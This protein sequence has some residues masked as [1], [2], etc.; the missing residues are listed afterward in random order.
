MAR[1]VYYKF[2]SSR[3]Y[4]SIPIDAPFISVSACKA[5]IFASKRY[6]IGK[7]FDLLISHAQTDEQYADGS[8]LIPA[9][10]S[11]L[12]RRVPGNPQLPIVIGEEKEK[13]NIK[14]NPSS[15]VND[16]QEEEEEKG[17]DF[18][19]FGLDFNS[20]PKNSTANPSNAHC[21]E[22]KTDDGFKFLAVKRV[23]KDPNPTTRLCLP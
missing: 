14:N 1:V 7:D 4:H 5:Q 15:V 18:N 16:P 23:W 9:N 8:S 13:P 11:L 22:D 3:D 2:K 20:I 12:I 17:F 10:S 21:K 6:S 19:D